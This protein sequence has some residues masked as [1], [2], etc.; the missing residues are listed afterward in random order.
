MKT[1]NIYKA[2]KELI[3]FRT[4]DNISVEEI[5]SG[6]YTKTDVCYDYEYL[7]PDGFHF[8]IDIR[9]RILELADILVRTSF[10]FK[11][12]N[13]DLEEIFTPFT[14][15]DFLRVAFN[16]TLYLFKE[17]CAD[18]GI[19]TP[20]DVNKHFR[21]RKGNASNMLK[22]ID[23]RKET[24]DENKALLSIPLVYLDL[25]FADNPIIRTTFAVLDEVLFHN[26]NF[27]TERNRFIFLKL[28]HYNY[29][30]TLKAKCFRS[31]LVELE[32]NLLDSVMFLQMLDGV[33]ILLASKKAKI[34]KDSLSYYNIGPK[35]LKMFDE[36]SKEFLAIYDNFDEEAKDL[37]LSITVNREWFSK[38]N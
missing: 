13:I 12:T 37:D 2:E 27:D 15:Y 26:A 34:I 30:L 18:S 19:E 38:M 23:L 9:F 25:G 20:E 10:I 5:D 35:D 8:Y 1:Q 21:V 31:K 4:F 36:F 32:L 7:S 29:Y 3:W 28:C 33:K 17:R 24:D 22:Y 14:V 16:N 11:Q 6:P